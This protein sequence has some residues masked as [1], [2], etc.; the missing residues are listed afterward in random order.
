MLWCVA[1]RK[2]RQRAAIRDSPYSGGNPNVLVSAP[3]LT[4]PAPVYIRPAS[5]F[6]NAE[7]LLDGTLTRVG[8]PTDQ[9]IELTETSDT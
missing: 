3:A 4:E 9:C 8:T 5:G 7:G 2:R 6:D 1:E